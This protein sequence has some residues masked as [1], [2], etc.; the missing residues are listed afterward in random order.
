MLGKHER[1]A[2]H[3]H[4]AALSGWGRTAP[5]VA[6]LTPV[7]SVEATRDAL[8]QAPE[9]GVI[10]RGLGRSYGD[11]AQNGG[12]MV[13]DCTP[14]GGIGAVSPDGRVVVGGGVSL[15]ALIAAVLPQGWFL[16][17][18]PGTRQVTIG[19]AIAADVHGKNH[20]RDGAFA[21][22]VEAMTLLL[23]SGEA[24]VVTQESDPDLFW[25]TAGGMGLTGVVVEAT[26][27]LLA[28]ETRFI[29]V[30]TTQSRNLDETM[31][32][33]IE[34]ESARYSVAWIDLATR[35]KAMGRGVVTA[36]NHAP[37]S[38]LPADAQADARRWRPKPTPSVP[39]VFPSWVVNRLTARMF[40]EAYFRI[41]PSGKAAITP[42]EAF[43]YPLDI[44]ND[45][46]RVYGRPG[47]VQWQCV[48]PMAETERM[49]TIVHDLVHGPVP[50]TLAVL[51]RFG[52]ASPGHLAFP[53]PGWTLAVD[54]PAARGDLL[55]PFLDRLDAQ[56]VE[57]GGRLYLAKD[58]RMRPE[59]LPTMYPRLDE[60]RAVQARVDPDGRLT[61]DL[62]RRLGITARAAERLRRTAGGAR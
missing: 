29:T 15:D 28:V 42:L 26:V 25:A 2:T 45:W 5:T 60:W 22:Y 50:A 51:K 27:R 16:P 52:A 24:R 49:R 34:S 31:A 13:L 56:V 35:G 62:D 3:A 44:V 30:D 10:P 23:P 46:N 6:D 39:P 54:I 4:R 33:I 58:A 19:G 14:L 61:S 59:L 40:D 36:G 57:G 1:P 12:G 41:H 37:L 7:A 53:S 32:A 20:H 9:R 55:A 47:F 38:A 8:R 43:F 21:R 11:A 18:T 17:V 48:L